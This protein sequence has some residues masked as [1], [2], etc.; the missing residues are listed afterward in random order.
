M[1]FHLKISDK[2]Y[3]KEN[4]LASLGMVTEQTCVV[5]LGGGEKGSLWVIKL[6][7]TGSCMSAVTTLIDLTTAKGSLPTFQANLRGESFHLYSAIP[8]KCALGE[9]ILHFYK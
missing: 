4:R 9:N 1:Q 2:F 6:I 7:R 8:R 5:W 3:F